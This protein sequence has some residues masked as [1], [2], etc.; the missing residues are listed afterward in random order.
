[1]A[2]LEEEQF[3][4]AG[5]AFEA[6]LAGELSTE[7][8][9]AALLYLARIQLMSGKTKEAADNAAAAF[10]N[11]Q[12]SGGPWQAQMAALALRFEAATVLG[13]NDQAQEVNRQMGAMA[14]QR[15]RL[16]W[17]RGLAP[18]AIVHKASG[19][20]LPGAVA[21]LVESQLQSYDDDGE[22]ASI[23]YA[24]EDDDSEG[25]EHQASAVT[26][27]FT[28]NPGRTLEDHFAW[29]RQQISDHHPDAREITS[30]P[31]TVV[32]KD[33]RLEGRMGVFSVRENGE[34][35][36]T[37][38]HV[39]RLSPDTHVRFNAS[40]PTTNAESMRNSVAALM[41][42]MVWPEGQTIQ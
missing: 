23:T 32:E 2:L 16:A 30:A 27:Y 4:Q 13:D 39:F 12:K 14:Q 17:A 10:D 7:Q 28:V 33:R 31:I 21:G 36:F 25:T 1:M 11:I 20:V 18:N 41:Q 22:E 40:Y 29:A 34:Q 9:G 42:S 38:V 3:E 8:R 35:M 37:T 24:S 26:V 15:E 5:K 19:A 6:A